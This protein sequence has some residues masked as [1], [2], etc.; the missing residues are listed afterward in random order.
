MPSLSD[1]TDPRMPLVK[2]R[3][4]IGYVE[5]I[6]FQ[7]HLK[8]HKSGGNVMECKNVKMDFVLHNPNAKE[9]TLNL[10]CLTDVIIFLGRKEK[11]S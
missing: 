4:A 11:Y 10:T 7:T 5:V 6:L 1:S 9:K 3:K 2:W 8:Q